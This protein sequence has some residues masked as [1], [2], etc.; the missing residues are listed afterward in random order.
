MKIICKRFLWNEEVQ[1]RDKALLVWETLCNSK[2]EGAL[3]ILDIQTQ[4]KATIIKL[5]WNLAKQKDK[6]SVIWVHSYYIKESRSWDTQANQ[7]SWVV[8]KIL[9]GGT[10]LEK[11]GISKEGIMEADTYNIKKIQQAKG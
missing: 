11:A 6:L 10:W 3:I 7:D 8:R 4:N 2:T 1:N 9:Q 5:L